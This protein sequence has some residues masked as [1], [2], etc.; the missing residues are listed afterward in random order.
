MQ[1]YEEKITSLINNIVN[2]FIDD[3]SNK[4]NVPKEELNKLWSKTEDKK[5][6]EE[7]KGSSVSYD[8]MK[9]PE[10]IKICKELGI[11]DKGNKKDLITRIE[12]KKTRKETIV[13][14][15][16]VSLN[17]IIIKKNKFGNYIH[18]PTKFVFNKNTKSVIGK[19]DDDGNIIQLNTNDIN[20]CNRY[21]FKYVVPDDLNINKDES[22]E[23]D[24]IIDDESEEELEDDDDDE[25]VD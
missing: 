6:N 24:E 14:K 11:S 21:K 8:S 16:N 13:E 12:K 1:T 25:L 3:V 19:E 22:E 9:K 23:D 5:C 15:L 7:V 10:L 2:N 4:Y 17:S 20:I 18:S